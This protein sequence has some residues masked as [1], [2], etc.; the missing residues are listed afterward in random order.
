M[1]RSIL[2][3]A[4]LTTAMVLAGPALAHTGAGAS[5]GFLAGASHPVTGIDHLLAMVAV[6]LMASGL[7]GRSLI[8][9]PA[10]FVAFMAGGAVLGMA[11]IAMPAVEVG[12]ALSLIAF[13]AVIATRIQLTT[14]LAVAAT[15]LFAL[16][17]GHAHGTEMPLA[18]SGLAY[19][20]GFVLATAGLHLAGI[21]AGLGVE[22][23]L[24]KTGPAIVRIAGVAVAA[25]GAGLLVG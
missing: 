7:K 1:K 21:G 11:G 25:V 17:H 12:I 24:E 22:R 5:N 4:V 16:F 2:S 6:G 3:G 13:G 20:S 14:A 9:V 15:G 10:A 19:A 23:L 8:A 18:A